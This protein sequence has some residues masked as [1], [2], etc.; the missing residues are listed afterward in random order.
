MTRGKEPCTPKSCVEGLPTE[1]AVDG[2]MQNDERGQIFI[3]APQ[4]VRQ[5]G[6]GAR[7]T[8]KLTSRLNV[9]DGRI[10]VDRLCIDRFDHR[11]VIHHSGGV[12]Q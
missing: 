9:G 5:P 3:H 10:V 6:P 11:Q 2:R 8:G 1:T 12:R 7:S 4:P